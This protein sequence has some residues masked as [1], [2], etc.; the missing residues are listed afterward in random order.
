MTWGYAEYGGDSSPL[1]RWLRGSVVYIASTAKAFTALKAAGEVRSWGTL[2]WDTCEAA[3]EK[4]KSSVVK[5]VYANHYCFAAFTKSGSAATWGYPDYGGN[6]DDV[7]E[8]LGCDVYHVYGTQ[9]AFA[10]V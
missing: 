9:M 3:N 2:E 6:S 1:R 8:E 5:E 4:L 7:Q 10:A